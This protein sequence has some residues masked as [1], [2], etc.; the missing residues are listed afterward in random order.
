MPQ[1]YQS[2]ATIS[3]CDQYRYRL[4]RLADDANPLAFIMLNPSTADAS[5]DDPTIRRCLGFA[6]SHGYAGIEVFNLYA[7]RATDP[8]KLLSHPA[9]V[10]PDNDFHLKLAAA[11]HKQ[12]VC[13][14]G[15]NAKS[16]RVEHVRQMFL[17]GGCQL[18][19]LGKNKDGS[20]KHPLY[21][22]SDLKITPW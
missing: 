11:Q 18:M 12:L 15:G 7:L 8:K 5:I 16:G 21:L 2:S 6:T 9:P 3:S 10:G 22:P 19:C 17:D 14:W 4:S 1:T 20:P 13:A